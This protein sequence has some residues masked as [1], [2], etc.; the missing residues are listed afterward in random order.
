MLKTLHF[1]IQ[2]R[3]PRERVWNI[4]LDK[5]SYKKWTSVFTEGSYY[6]GSWNKGE[7]I[8]FLDPKGSGMTAV[9]AEN[10]PLEFI[11]IKHLGYI[12]DGVEDKDSPEIK[13]WAP[14]YENYTFTSKNGGTELH[15]EAQVTADFESYMNKTWPQALDTLRKLCES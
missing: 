12:K 6:K 8:Q 9:I 4:M 11:S 5:E 3:A 7:T 14:A 2:I 10:R 15:I 1:S 13:A